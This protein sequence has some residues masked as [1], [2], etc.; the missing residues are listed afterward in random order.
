[1]TE[2]STT[3]PA[4]TGTDSRNTVVC[5]SSPVSSMRSEPASAITADR[6]VE[7]KSPAVM[8]ATL[9]VDDGDQAPI[10]CG[11]VRA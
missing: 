4:V 1:M 3:S 5:P 11:W 10:E 8:C 6:S 2:V 9:V 7:R